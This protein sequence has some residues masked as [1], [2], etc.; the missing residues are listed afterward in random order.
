MS[1]KILIIEDEKYLA[2]MYKWKLEKEGYIADFALDGQA[3]VEKALS[4]NPDLI[5]LDLVMPVM[6]GYKT[7]EVLRQTP[8]T[9][10]TPIYIFSNLGQVEE[11]EKGMHEGAD[12]FLVKAA[13]TPSDLVKKIELVLAGKKD[14]NNI[15]TR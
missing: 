13:L 7:L 3:G 12:G 1:K 2:E 6:D 10:K 15:K 5:L 4:M 11:V 14:E 8:S 9:M